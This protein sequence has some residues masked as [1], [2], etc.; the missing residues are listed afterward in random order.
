MKKNKNTLK[1]ILSLVGKYPL[2]VIAVILFAAAEVAAT[3]YVPILVGDGVD[4][5]AGK[6][7]VDFDGLSAVF[8][9]IG[10]AIAVGFVAKWLVGIFNNRLAFHVVQNIRDEAFDKITSLPLKYLDSH[11]H[12]D[13]LSRIVAD[14]D[15]VS[16]G[17]VMGFTQLF[18]GVLTIGGTIALMLLTNWKIALVVIFV[19]PLSIFTSRFIAKRT[20]SFFRKQTL[21]RA[22]QVSFTEEA[23]GN[24]KT[25]QAFAHEK[26]N[27][28]DFAKYNGNYKE[29][30]MNATF[31]SSL[32]NPLTRFLNNAVYALVVLFGALQIASGTGGLTVGGLTK[33]LSYANQYTKPFNEISGVITELSGAFVCAARIFELLDE[34]EEVSDENN[35]EL[36]VTE[37]K[38]DLRD[39]SFAYTEGQKLIEHLSLTAEGGK[40]IAIVGRTGSGKTTLINLLMRFYDVNGGGNFRGFAGDSRRDEKIFARA[41][42]YGASGDVFK[43]G[44]GAR[45][46]E[47]RAGERDGRRDGGSRESLPCA[48]IYFPPAQG[49]RYGTDGR[50]ESF[51]RAETTF[52][53]SENHAVA[54]EYA[55]SRRGDVFRGYAHRKEDFRGVRQTD[56]GAHLLYRGAP[57]FHDT[58]R[59]YYSRDGKGQRGGA[60]KSRNAAEKTRIL[61][62]SVYEPV[63]GDRRRGE[64][65]RIRLRKKAADLCDPSRF[66]ICARRCRFCARMPFLSYGAADFATLFAFSPRPS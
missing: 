24:L 52:V 60:G 46:S 16:D 43:D 38:V 1:R 55:D 34:Q 15:E 9:K 58:E 6:G 37:G 40:R 57:P 42:R 56:D 27:E 48:R 25:A 14:A 29:A 35:A 39:V 3:L 28:E 10:I 26:K 32:T 45:K 36:T 30:A 11:P 51:R 54:S 7:A 13:T 2:S 23:V 50:S 31:Y 21:A 17:L 64:P 41:L 49:V 47:N 4:L 33:F 66:R 20:Y 63:C 44:Y 18:T 8:L 62:R 12:G 5:I 53:Y 59:R 22:G 65:R 61:L 19:T